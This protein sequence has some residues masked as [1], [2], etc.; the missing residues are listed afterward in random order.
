MGMKL[1]LSHT[2]G[3]SLIEGVREQVLRGLFGPK[4]EEMARDWR[5]LHSEELH[6]FHASPNIIRM[7][8]SRRMRW[9][10]HVAGMEEV[11]NI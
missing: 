1:E 7:I 9:T 2:S 11:R 8:K 10:G 4:R 3:T 5:R 6:D